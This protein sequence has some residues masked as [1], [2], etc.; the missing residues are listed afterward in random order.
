VEVVTGWQFASWQYRDAAEGE[1]GGVVIHFAP[2]GRVDIHEGLARREVRASVAAA[3]SETPAAPKA[4]PEYTRPLI[5]YMAAHKTLAV[6]AALLE[7]PRKAREVAVVQM[8][9]G[10][11]RHGA[12]PINLAVHRSVDMLSR[13]EERGRGYQHVAHEASLLSRLLYSLQDEEGS[14]TASDHAWSRLANDTKDPLAL[15][16]DVRHLTDEELERLHL[17]LTVLTFG[18]SNMDKHDTGESLFNEVA[19][20]L[21]VNMRLWWRPDEAFLSRRRKDQL[22]DIARESGAAKC[23]GRRLKDYK[24][25]DLVKVLARYFQTERDWLPEAMQFPAVTADAE[26]EAEPE[27]AEDTDDDTETEDADADLSEAA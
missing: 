21:E 26:P 18:Q 8:M 19:R 7:N 11:D 6:Q 17:L 4:Q 9:R 27:E 3:T 16:A 10:V 22:E 25:A 14:G 2:S 24:K 20:D 1:T 5:N 13:V 23:L 15:Y 12:F